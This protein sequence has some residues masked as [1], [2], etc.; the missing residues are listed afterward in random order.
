[1]ALLTIAHIKYLFQE[2]D[3]PMKPLNDVFSQEIAG[4]DS[5][6]ETCQKIIGVQRKEQ[7]EERLS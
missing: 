7:R 2:L 1:M 3:F 4:I 6:I 5:A